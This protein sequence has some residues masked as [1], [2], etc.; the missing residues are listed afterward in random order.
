MKKLML[1]LVL[2]GLVACTAYADGPIESQAF[3]PGVSIEE[4]YQSKH[5]PATWDVARFY[6]WEFSIAINT[7]RRASVDTSYAA[8]FPVHAASGNSI[9]SL[10]KK[11]DG[12]LATYAEANDSMTEWQLAHAVAELTHI[13]DPSN[14]DEGNFQEGIIQ[15]RRVARLCGYSYRAPYSPDVLTEYICGGTLSTT[16]TKLDPPSNCQ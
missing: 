2:V 16:S 14:A 4:Y 10:L 1:M 5:F 8:S 9:Y 11:I 12:D 3:E 7:A 15:G 6:C 13:A